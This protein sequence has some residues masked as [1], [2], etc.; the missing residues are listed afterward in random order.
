MAAGGSYR[1]VE[2]SY[3][4]GSRP[5]SMLRLVG[6]CGRGTLGC[7]CDAVKS[8]FS[9]ETLGELGVLHLGGV[10]MV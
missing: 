2:G 1:L 10:R 3:P 7:G 6:A 5:A 9:R 4:H 8:S